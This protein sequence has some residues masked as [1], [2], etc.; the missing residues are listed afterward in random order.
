LMDRS[1][2]GAPKIEFNRQKHTFITPVTQTTYSVL[3]TLESFRL[4]LIIQNE[5][6]YFHPHWSSWCSN[7]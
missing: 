1:I 3:I 4:L 7:R 2:F 6:S 5:R